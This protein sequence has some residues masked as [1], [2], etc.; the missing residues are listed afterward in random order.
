MLVWVDDDL[1]QRLDEIIRKQ[2]FKNRSEAVSA[3]VS[4]MIEDI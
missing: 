4:R 1:R 2:R 3:A